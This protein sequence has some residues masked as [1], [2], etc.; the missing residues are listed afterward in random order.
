MINSFKNAHGQDVVFTHQ[1]QDLLE[2]YNRVKRFR[3]RNMKDLDGKGLVVN[4]RSTYALSNCWWDV[5]QLNGKPRKYRSGWMTSYVYDKAPVMQY[6]RLV[7]PPRMFVG[8]LIK[9]NAAFKFNFKVIEFIKKLEKA[10]RFQQECIINER[11]YTEEEFERY[12]AMIESDL[13][14][15]RQLREICYPA[16]TGT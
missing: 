2:A 5:Y 6:E 1:D 14:L 13:V 3:I 15:S 4:L 7:I 12:R 9:Y 16:D 11:P 8:T 10:D